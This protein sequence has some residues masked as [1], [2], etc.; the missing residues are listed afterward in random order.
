MDDTHQAG[1]DPPAEPT[2]ARPVRTSAAAVEA[3]V[4]GIPFWLL[5]LGGLG[6]RVLVVLLLASV[7]VGIAW[8]LSTMTA[9]I[10]VAA[11]AATA[12]WPIVSRLRA[13]GWG[14]ARAA[15]AGTALVFG[16]IIVV[17]SIAA[18]VL[19]VH[20]PELVAAVHRGLDDVRSDVAAGRLPP[21]ILDAMQTIADGTTS[22]LAANLG[23][24]ANQVATLGTVLLLGGFTTFYVLADDG[25]GWAWLTQALTDRRRTQAGVVAEASVHQLGGYLRSQ[26]VRSAVNGVVAYLLLQLFGVP[27]ALPLGTLVFVAG[28]VPYLGALVA[29][30]ALLVVAFASLGSGGTLLL[31]ALL[32]AARV[33]E[34]RLLF[35]RSAITGSHVSPALILISLPIGAY[36][37]GFFG[38]VVAVPVAVALTSGVAILAAQ[39]RESTAERE[40]PSP[41]VPAWLD[42]LAGW[43]WR[44]LVGLALIVV[45]L[46]PIILIPMLALPLVIAAVMAATLAP[47][48]A[49][50]VRRGLG[51]S[52]ASAVTT[53][54]VTGTII[55]ISAVSVAALVGQMAQLVIKVR[56][57]AEHANDAAGGLGGLLV[58][59]GDEVS[60]SI[61]NTVVG[62]SV[63]IAAVVLV[64][65]VGVILTFVALRDGEG[66]WAT[67]TAPMAPWRRREIDAAATRSVSVLSGYMLG[68][69]AL[70]LFGAG[71][72]FVMMVLMGAPLALPV[73]TLSF[74][75][76]YI[77]YIGTM[78][79]TLLANLLVI[80][81]GNLPNVIVFVVLTLILNVVQGSILA[82]LVFS[83]AVNVHPA[84]ILLA[85]SAGATLGGML[86]MFLVVPVLG[87]V[88]TTWRTVLV[89]MGQPP[90]EGSGSDVADD[91]PGAGADAMPPATTVP[92]T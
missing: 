47:I 12:V 41:L 48:A 15:A 78:I 54:G 60:N 24:I 23:T 34:D 77:P 9:A 88:A 5:R 22:W 40:G 75:S 32:I 25:H 55:V 1:M 43:S 36:M 17:V 73:F 45:A 58:N 29:Y 50:L 33:L 37:A 21:Q 46:L 53:L 72:Q 87:L 28:L 80:S 38:L 4:P 70:S 59:L 86:G 74:F 26:T 35:A 62:L 16:S 82:P 92:A 42:V 69:G 84:V 57:G 2:A 89:V 91:A 63:G 85:T 44:L 68:T 3:D 39:L 18:L 66:A 30:A 49:G 83:R 31:A 65:T 13:R 20:G 8:A 61:A 67:L 27:L 10:I 71:T 90:A 19:V 14:L 11:L 56:L 6:W 51:R 76:G 52:L 81:T 64:V 7:A 79:T